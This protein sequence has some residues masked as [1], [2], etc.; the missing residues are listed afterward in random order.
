MYTSIITGSVC[1]D[2]YNKY[3]YAG[4][5]RATLKTVAGG[6]IEAKKGVIITEIVDGSKYGELAID[7]LYSR[8]SRSQLMMYM[9][10]KATSIVHSKY[11]PCWLS[12]VYV[13]DPESTLV[14]KGIIQYRVPHSWANNGK[15]IVQISLMEAEMGIAVISVHNEN[16]HKL[17]R[18]CKPR[19]IYGK[20]TGNG[21]GMDIH[22]S[23]RGDVSVAWVM[24]EI[25]Y[26]SQVKRLAEKMKNGGVAK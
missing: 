2:C 25:L 19:M 12:K 16:D 6:Y 5:R 21:K 20:Y 11:A 22:T 10:T 18:G 4:E 1:C 9:L 15:A 14:H 17:V 13:Q 3:M 23:T 26:S 7:M 24:W 8:L